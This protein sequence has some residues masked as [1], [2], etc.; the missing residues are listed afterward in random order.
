MV[1]IL[2]E[3]VARSRSLPGVRAGEAQSWPSQ[4][5][6]RS[7]ATVTASNGGD[8][9]AGRRA[10]LF[11]YAAPWMLAL[12]DLDI[13]AYSTILYD[14]LAEYSDEGGYAD[15]FSLGDSESILKWRQVTF[16]D[17]KIGLQLK[18]SSDKTA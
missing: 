4:S 8:Y 6:Y 18:S 7:S 15:P 13:A 5:I 3:F 17:P 14:L 11:N 16:L 1:T 2:R 10:L 12:H 9:V